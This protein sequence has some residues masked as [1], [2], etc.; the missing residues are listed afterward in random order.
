MN[1]EHLDPLSRWRFNNVDLFRRVADV[2]FALAWSSV[3]HE[4]EGAL[5]WQAVVRFCR[6][7]GW[8]F[9]ISRIPSRNRLS[10]KALAR[11]GAQ[12]RI[13]IRQFRV[14]WTL[15]WM[16]RRRHRAGICKAFFV[17]FKNDEAAFPEI[18]SRPRRS[19]S[20]RS[21]G[22]MIFSH[23]CRCAQLL[24]YL[25]GLRSAEL[26]TIAGDLFLEVD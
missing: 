19:P 22:E 14:F 1:V 23:Y 6:G 2:N 3:I 25:N 8:R 7:C 21:Q 5:R 16:T 26:A 10:L 18:P 13:G 11:F 20:G 12:T 24:D 9:W 15:R 17:T 4:L